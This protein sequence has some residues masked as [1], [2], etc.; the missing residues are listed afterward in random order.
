MGGVTYNVVSMLDG[1]AE[2]S[3][4]SSLDGPIESL[5]ML[6]R[7]LL[8]AE[9]A[10]LSYLSRA[11]AGLLANRIG[12]PEI[13]FYDREGAQAYIFAND[14]D[15][16]V[17]CRGTEP[18]DWNDVKADLDLGMA[19]AETVGWVHRGFK[20]EVDDLWPRLE[21]ALVNNTRTLWFSGHSLGGAMAAICAGRCRL[22][23]IRSN[24][25]A[26]FTF[27]S[28]RVG[29]RR[30]VNYVQIE[31]YRWVNNN[32]IVPRVPPAWLGFRHKGQEVYLNAYGKIRE[33]T[34]WQRLKDRWRGFVRGLEEGRIDF[35]TDHSI[36]RYIEHIRGAV[37][38][39]EGVTLRPNVGRRTVLRKP[40]RV[41]A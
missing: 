25:R 9:L 26:L 19:M 4:Y 30:Y 8:F 15:T 38:Q 27:G 22:S 16:V 28:P 17:T 34:G 20:H 18:N 14:D 33:L 1:D 3:V 41:A 6:R 24:P 40:L 31:T 12:F 11:E 5:S 37:E 13:R 10:N 21:Q 23:Y 36:R 32:D 29:S 2:T 39:E 7:S 35:F